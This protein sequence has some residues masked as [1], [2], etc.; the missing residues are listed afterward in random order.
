VTAWTPDRVLA[1]A[2]AWIWVPDE[3]RVVERD[4]Y[5][6][7]DFPPGY[8]DEVPTQVQ[9]TRSSRPPAELVDEVV[10]Q[11]RAW[12]RHRCSWWLRDD[13]T[14]PRLAAELAARGAAVHDTVNVLALKLSDDPIAEVEGVTWE[15]VRDERTLRDART[16]YREVWGGPE[17]TAEEWSRQLAEVAQPVGERPHFQV[18][19]YVDG[20]PASAGGC[21]RADDVARLWGAASRPALRG[22]GAYRALT[23]ARLAIARGHG[24][25]L[26]LVRAR[27]STSGPILR[28][29]GFTSY[30]E[31]RLLALDW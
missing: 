13:T 22:R 27:V 12:G 1:A 18:V 11:A 17:P 3:A 25:T 23:H 21:S 19:A 20:E 28:R 2:A 5:L 16:V 10:A 29:L 7:V 9:W 26:G 30:G 6:L 31:E 24:A 15:V 14:P 8:D 4:D